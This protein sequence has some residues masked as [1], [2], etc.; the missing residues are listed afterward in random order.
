[1]IGPHARRVQSGEWI[2]KWSLPG[3][4]PYEVY[5]MSSKE[6]KEYTKIFD[7]LYRKLEEMEKEENN[8]K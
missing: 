2:Y 4:H 3:E 5:G 8:K 7:E 1:M 6:A